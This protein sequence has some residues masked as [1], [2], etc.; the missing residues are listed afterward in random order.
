MTDPHESNEREWDELGDLYSLMFNVDPDGH[1]EL[2]FEGA[3]VV[4]LWRISDGRVLVAWHEPR[5]GQPDAKALLQLRRDRPQFLGLGEYENLAP[6]AGAFL[7]LSLATD[8]SDDLVVWVGLR[9]RA[10][11]TVPVE[12]IRRKIAS[13]S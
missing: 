4:R 13:F 11:I 9:R 7:R 3:Q 10:T 8:L 6:P 5:D 1:R 2:R 12:D